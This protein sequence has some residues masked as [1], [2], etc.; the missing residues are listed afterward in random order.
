MQVVAWG[1]YDM[2]GHWGVYLNKRKASKLFFFLAAKGQPGMWGMR[3][4]QRFW[5]SQLGHQGEPEV[6]LLAV[7]SAQKEQQRESQGKQEQIKRKKQK[8]KQNKR[9]KEKEAEAEWPPNHSN[10]RRL[11]KNAINKCET[12]PMADSSKEQHK[13]SNSM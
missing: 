3:A 13:Q 2:G 6:K 10:R 4:N 5:S 12:S 1:V 9:K 11:N 8:Q 7:K